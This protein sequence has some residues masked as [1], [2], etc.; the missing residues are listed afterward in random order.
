MRR[1]LSDTSSVSKGS[2]DQCDRIPPRGSRTSHSLQEEDTS[3]FSSHHHHREASTPRR[4]T[5]IRSNKHR[6]IFS[7]ITSSA[8]PPRRQRPAARENALRVFQRINASPVRLFPLSLQ[9]CIYRAGGLWNKEEKKKPIARRVAESSGEKDQ[10]KVAEGVG[11]ENVGLRAAE[12]LVVSSGEN[13]IFSNGVRNF[14]DYPHDRDPCHHP[15]SFCDPTGAIGGGQETH[16]LSPPPLPQEGRREIKNVKEISSHDVQWVEKVAGHHVGQGGELF[17]IHTPSTVF[18]SLQR[19]LQASV[20]RGSSSSFSSPPSSSEAR[21]RGQQEEERPFILPTALD[22]TSLHVKEEE[23]RKERKEVFLSLFYQDHD[24]RHSCKMEPND[25]PTLSDRLSHIHMSELQDWSCWPTFCD[26]AFDSYVGAMGKK[27]NKNNKK[28]N[29]DADE[30]EDGCTTSRT[31]GSDG[32]GLPNPTTATRVSG[33]ATITTMRKTSSERNSS[34]TRLHGRDT[35]SFSFSSSIQE[36]GKFSSTIDGKQTDR[37]LEDHIRPPQSP[38][39]PD[40]CTRLPTSTKHISSDNKARVSLLVITLHMGYL[41]EYERFTGKEV[42]FVPSLL[43]LLSRLKNAAII[44]MEH[45]AEGVGTEGKAK[46]TPTSCGTSFLFSG[47][48]QSIPTRGQC[49]FHHAK[50]MEKKGFCNLLPPLDAEVGNEKRNKDGGDEEEGVCG[51]EMRG[52][53]NG[54]DTT[55]IDQ[56]PPLLPPAPSPHSLLA[57]PSL[58]LSTSERPSS[59]TIT[60]SSRS[61]TN[62]F[63]SFFPPFETTGRLFSNS[64]CSSSILSRFLSFLESTSTAIS[65]IEKKD[66]KHRTPWVSSSS[67]SC[68][69]S[70]PF[71]AIPPPF[72]TG[73]TAPNSTRR[74][75]C[76]TGAGT[77]GSTINALWY[78]QLESYFTSLLSSSAASSLSAQRCGGSDFHCFA[79]NNSRSNKMTMKAEL[80]GVEKSEATGRDTGII[81][82]PLNESEVFISPVGEK[83]VMKGI[84]GAKHTQRTCMDSENENKKETNCYNGS[85]DPSFLQIQNVIVV[86]RPITRGLLFKIISTWD[87]C[88]TMKGSIN[89]DGHSWGRVDTHGNAHR[90][91][92]RAC[93]ISC[94]GR[95]K[96]R[97]IEGPEGNN[98]GEYYSGEIRS[99]RTLTRGSTSFPVLP[100]GSSNP[101]NYMFAVFIGVV[102]NMLH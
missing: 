101:K 82:S 3:P 18:L 65:D 10:R 71:S 14:H 41:L 78:L 61:T 23:R 32:V 84:N 26:T 55:R 38:L 92:D 86:A 6:D 51:K 66:R 37:S 47:G 42:A 31:S 70:F 81:S 39:P 93:I 80:R 57:P 20:V 58:L 27:E 44:I 9:E 75:S 25:F 49:S 76:S 12:V 48:P 52:S 98:D 16:P 89:A 59:N 21:K 53:Q 77:G 95:M 63:S 17:V 96:R 43:S 7:F 45:R 11:D 69:S 2:R 83:M 35:C 46:H 28:D 73:C 99:S 19:I 24:S 5:I 91:P 4:P 88:G 40:S 60:T 74:G 87:G 67:S 34:E 68:S 56:I 85:D 15:L 33:G 94:A 13:R 1:K 79:D 102:P 72:L 36:G 8:S 50:D 54:K 97:R 29:S 90:S 30:G 64:S 100:R 62:T 22:S